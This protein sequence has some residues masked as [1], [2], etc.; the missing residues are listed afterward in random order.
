MWRCRLFDYTTRT[1]PKQCGR[2]LTAIASDQ[3]TNEQKQFFSEFFIWYEIL[4]PVSFLLVKAPQKLFSDKVWSFSNIF[5][6]MIFI[7]LN[8]SWKWIFSLRKIKVT[9][10]KDWWVWSV[11]HSHNPL[12][13]QQYFVK[14]LLKRASYFCRLALTLQLFYITCSAV[15]KSLLKFWIMKFE[16]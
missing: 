5:L 16:N 14:K 13:S 12:S 9:R 11:L 2:S 1:P 10:S 7:L 15:Y 4:T 6:V 8:L 3:E